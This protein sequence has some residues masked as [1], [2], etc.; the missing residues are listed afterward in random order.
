MTPDELRFLELIKNQAALRGVDSA[1]YAEAVL[2]AVQEGF[3]KCPGDKQAAHAY[4]SELLDERYPVE[5]LYQDIA[6]KIHII[7]DKTGM[8]L[9]DAMK[10][11]VD[12]ALEDEGGP[13]CL[14]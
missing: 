12:R 6:D 11:I 14:N 5:K 7:A 9:N 1:E 8:I 13:P 10:M 3:E 2:A 4:T